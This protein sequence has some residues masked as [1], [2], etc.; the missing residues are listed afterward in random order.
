MTARAHAAVLR[1]SVFNVGDGRHLLGTAFAVRVL[2]STRQGTFLLTAAHTVRYAWNTN[3]KLTL[4]DANGDQLTGSVLACSEDFYPDVALIYVPG[5]II[6]PLAASAATAAGPVIVKGGLSGVLTDQASLGGWCYGQEYDQS[7]RYLDIVLSDLA[8][9]EPDSTRQSAE[10]NDVYAAL[11]GLSGAPVVQADQ[12]VPATAIGL[13]AKRNTH[14][15]ANRVYAIPMQ[16]AA[17]QLQRQGFYLDVAVA[18][19]SDLALGALAG[20]LITRILESSDGMHELWEDVSGLFYSGLPMDQIIRDAIRRPA[21]YGLDGGLAI[22]ELEYLLARLL[23][24]RGQ[25]TEA[26]QLFLSAG[27]GAAHGHSPAHRRLSALVRL[28]EAGAA[29]AT[30]HR[31][32]RWLTFSEAIRSY[33]NLADFSEHERAYEIASAVGAAAADFSLTERFLVRDEEAISVFNA[34][35]GRHTGLVSAYPQWLLAKQEPVGI[36]LQLTGLLWTTGDVAAGRE[37]TERILAV[38]T[39]G[40]SAARQRS[41]GIFYIQ[42][43]LARVIAAR[44]ASD[45]GTVF[46]LLGLAADALAKGGLTLNHEGL[47]VLHAYLQR[48]DPELARLLGFMSIHGVT[49]SDD[50][51]ANNNGIESRTVMADALHALRQAVVASEEITS[52]ADLLSLAP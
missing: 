43:M 13:I 41:N 35:A 17:N 36:M 30:N 23:L 16:D 9:V 10:L 1:Q 33:E 42:M 5:K 32:H 52:V 19:R 4:A 3:G 27:Q 26:G 47:K 15:I 12:A 51:F 20:R 37:H 7:R 6:E 50:F 2:D 46:Y 18:P 14:G 29:S 49:N 25:E 21:S 31:D 38:A 11:R 45:H 24:K 40:A 39:R 28:R 22:H 48:S 8:I 34:M 44:A